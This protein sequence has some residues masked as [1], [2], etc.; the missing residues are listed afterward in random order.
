MVALDRQLSWLEAAKSVTLLRGVDGDTAHFSVD[1]TDTKVR[2]LWVDTEEVHGPRATLFGTTVA[3]TVTAWI[4]GAKTLHLRRQLDHIGRPHLD[5]Y[6]RTLALVFVDGELVQ[7]RMVREG[8]SPYYTK[9]GCAPVPLHQALLWSEAQARDQRRGVW[10]EHHP[11]DYRAESLR[12]LGKPRAHGRC[13][14]DPF[15]EPPCSQPAANASEP[16]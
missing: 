10:A 3:H 15:T 1:G 11:T 4:V 8:L 6:G 5:A 12:W 13:R 14:P 9:F 7:I 16:R 2:F